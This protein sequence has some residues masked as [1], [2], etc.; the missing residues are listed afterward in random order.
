MVFLRSSDHAERLGLRQS[1]GAFLLPN[2]PNEP[3]DLIR[4]VPLPAVA[5]VIRILPFV[6]FMSGSGAFECSLARATLPPPKCFC[7][8][9]PHLRLSA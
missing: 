2:K 8:F 6:R 7:A 1:S 5:A 9:L 4:Q 3:A